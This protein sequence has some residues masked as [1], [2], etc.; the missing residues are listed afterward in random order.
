MGRWGRGVRWAM[1]GAAA[2]GLGGACGGDGA[3]ADG[4]DAL[5]G[6][7]AAA[8]T[9]LAPPE[10]GFQ[11]VSA[12]LTIPSGTEQTW[13]WYFTVPTAEAVGVKRWESE[14][15]RGSHH[16]IVFFTAEAEEPDGTLVE[17]CDGIGGSILNAPVW[18]Q[19]G[20][21]AAGA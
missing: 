11:L 7:T 5:G 12:P 13:C 9:A 3:G 14:M 6:D 4:A 2:L 10:Q 17:G 15:T 16:M 19:Y 20:A 18:T 1:I 21:Q 8:D